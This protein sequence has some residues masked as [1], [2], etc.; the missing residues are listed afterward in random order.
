MWDGP[1]PG[2][3]WRRFRF[4]RRVA[5][6][7]MTENG[8]PCLR[9]RKGRRSSDECTAKSAYVAAAAS[10]PSGCSVRMEGILAV[11]ISRCSGSDREGSMLFWGQ[12]TRRSPCLPCRSAEESALCRASRPPPRRPYRSGIYRLGKY[13]DGR[14]TSTNYKLRRTSRSRLEHLFVILRCYDSVKNNVFGLVNYL[15]HSHESCRTQPAI[16]PC[17]SH[18]LSEV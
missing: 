17:I 6:Y 12:N 4:V 5:A 15:R 14:R 11:R 18:N 13:G 1:G 7:S 2:M 10:R 8:A 9:R 16:P 3:G